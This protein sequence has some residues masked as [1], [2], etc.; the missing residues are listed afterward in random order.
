VE[1]EMHAPVD[2]MVDGEIVRLR[3][4]TLEILPGAMDVYI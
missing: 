2:V 1:F 3:C 4:K